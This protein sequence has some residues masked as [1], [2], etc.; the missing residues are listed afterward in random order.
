MTAAGRI[1]AVYSDGGVVLKNPSPWAGTWAWVHVDEAGQVVN[2]GSG[3][4]PG[5]AARP[6]SNNV[7]ELEAAVRGIEA[8]P[9]GCTPFA[10]YT[11]SDVTAGRI[12]ATYSGTGYTY[13]YRGISDALRERAQACIARYE[14]G[15][16]LLAGHPT[17]AELA[18][19]RSRG[20]LPVS[21]HN[22]RCDAL[23]KE[24]AIEFLDELRELG[25]L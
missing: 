20:G 2:E 6:V 7:A 19:G 22:V 21:P 13:A 23:C 17:R 5:S 16:V 10:L 12:S 11:D 18:A 9:A 15:V 25:L 3:V 24:R 14:Y 4:L 8:L 1:V